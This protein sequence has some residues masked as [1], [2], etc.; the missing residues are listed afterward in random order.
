MVFES[1]PRNVRILL[2]G[3]PGVG[4]TSLIL[5][6]VTEE[7]TEHVPPKAEEITIPADVTPE[8]VPTNIVD[9][10]GKFVIL[11]IQKIIKENKT[12][13]QHFAKQCHVEINYQHSD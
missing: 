2:L 7:F 8:Q 10:C 11:I 1:I 4:K 13:C 9:I 5:S 3:D 6:L 12:F